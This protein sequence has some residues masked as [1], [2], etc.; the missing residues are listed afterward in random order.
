M[1]R[2]VIGTPRRLTQ[3]MNTN[4][5]SEHSTDD[6]ASKTSNGEDLENLIILNEDELM[7]PWPE[8]IKRA[9]RTA[10]KLITKFKI[11]EWT[12]V[13]LRKQWKWAQRIGNQSQNRWSKIAAQWQPD[14]DPTHPAARRQARPRTRWEDDITAF[15]H[16]KYNNDTNSNN[17]TPHWLEATTTTTWTTLEDEYVCFVTEKTFN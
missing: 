16:T 11:Q 9:T 2:L 7:E 13:F 4:D 6:V 14:L 5:P 12:T 3:N 10:E 17:T 1:L 15:L 8:F